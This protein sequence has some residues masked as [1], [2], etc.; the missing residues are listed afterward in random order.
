MNQIYKP[1]NNFCRQR[2]PSYVV[3]RIITIEPTRRNFEYLNFGC[4]SFTD[5]EIKHEKS[6]ERY[7]ALTMKRLN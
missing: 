2:N 6:D 1:E 7:R 3:N 4:E 5:S